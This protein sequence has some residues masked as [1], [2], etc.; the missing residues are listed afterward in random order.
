[1]VN[2]AYSGGSQNKNRNWRQPLRVRCLKLAPRPRKRL[3]TG[4]NSFGGNAIQT[5]KDEACLWVY[6]ASRSSGGVS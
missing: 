2:G 4:E 3:E 1:M 6:T 5:G